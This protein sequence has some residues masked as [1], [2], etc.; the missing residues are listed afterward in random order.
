MMIRINFLILVLFSFYS[1]NANELFSAPN[2]M[3]LVVAVAKYPKTG[4]WSQISSDKDVP[5]ITNALKTQGFKDI[6]IL[7]DADATKAGIIAA[8]EALTSKAQKGDIVVFHFSGHGQQIQDDNGDEKDDG[9]DEAIVPYNARVRYKPGV[10]EGE[11]HLR[12]DELDVL[13]NALRKKLGKEG[14]LLV[15]LDACHSGTATRGMAKARGT[16]DKLEKPG[17]QPQESGNQ[18]VGMAD[19]DHPD[20]VKSRGSVTDLASMVV[21]SGASPQQLNYE[22]RDDEGNSVGSLSFAFSRAV[23][24]SNKNTSYRS[25]FEDIKI[26]MSVLAPNQQPQIEGN[27][28]VTIFGGEVVEQAAYLTIEKWIDENTLLINGGSVMG[29]NPK[30]I[31]A[32]YPAGTADPGTVSQ[33]TGGEVVS[34]ENFSSTVKTS[35]PIPRSETKNM[36]VFI[37]EQN[38]GDLRVSVGMDIK[39]K[40][41]EDLVSKSLKEISLV[42]LDN[43]NPDLWIEYG[44]KYTRGNSLQV[45][46]ATDM[47]LFDKGFDQAKSDQIIHDVVSLIKGYAQGNLL[48]N[49]EM[50]STSYNVSF[51]FI[52]IVANKD[53]SE[54]S[55]FDISEKID[56]NNTIV[57][58]AGDYFKLRIKNNGNRMAYYSL[59]DIQPDNQINILIPVYD[60]KRQIRIPATDFVIRPGTTVELDYTFVFGPPFGM[61]V[62]KLIASETPLNL[63]PIILSK[64]AGSRGNMNPLE[65]L[66][67]DS[68]GTRGGGVGYTPNIPYGN[69]NTY[70][71][72][73]KISK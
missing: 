69:A 20:K 4:G 7:A 22:T 39:D 40:E 17:Y 15:I 73:F 38:Y 29:L 71:L 52:P 11:F 30:S 67:A 9:Y 45:T 56:K 64:G 68:Y 37:K 63:E 35:I 55:R 32:F 31:V 54:K 44:N 34:A 28:D 19:V 66:L 2:K 27:M 1:F 62:F 53:E 6:T 61:E 13:F 72:I 47:I 49:L 58:Q 3:A 21:L 42:T 33:I 5:L 24:K 46:T 57:F 59:I 25:F 43:K 65:L 10:Y 14:N 26:D 60:S 16:K 8:I 41:V 50:E 18:E 36:W 23:R 51:E 12:D 48:R 70:T